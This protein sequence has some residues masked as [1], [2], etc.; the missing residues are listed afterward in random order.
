[1]DVAAI[2][3]DAGLRELPKLV[4]A[5]ILLLLA[6][7]VGQRI[8]MNWNLRQKQKENEVQ[9]AHNFHTLYGEFFAIWK[10][11]NYYV[12]D[13]GAEQLP[14]VSRSSLLDRACSAEGRLES[15]LVRLACD[16]ALD[17]SQIAVL[18]Q[19]RQLYQQL[20]Q[21][22]RDNKA[23]AWDHA[24]HPHYL[25]F[26][27]T[28]PKVVSLIVRRKIVD[29]KTLQLITSNEWEAWL[30]GLSLQRTT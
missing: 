18:G 6:W 17:R 15:T 29:T 21:S 8:S 28:A 2:L 27:A 12:R 25:A 16:D 14:D 20:R 9:A 10:L 22:I 7:F 3:I 23:L 13:L 19:F 4:S 1:M 24:D 30:A 26:K 11:W 5:L